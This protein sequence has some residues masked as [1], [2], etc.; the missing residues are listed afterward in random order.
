MANPLLLLLNDSA[1]RRRR[2]RLPVPVPSEMPSTDA[3]FVM[4]RRLRMPL[5]VLVVILTISV[6]GLTLIP[7]ADGTHLSPFDAL[8]FMTYTAATIGYTEIVD[9]TT[10]QRM[11]V[12]FCIYLSVV[13]WAYAIGTSLNLLQNATVREAFA[14]HRFAAGVKRIREEFVIVVGYGKAGRQVVLELDAHGRRVVVIDK[15]E[16]A[17]D[18]LGTESLFADVPGLAAN[19]AISGVLGLAGMGSANC[20]AVLALTDNDDDNL[21]IVMA[22]SLLRPDVPVIARCDDRLTADRMREFDAGAVIQPSDKFGEYLILAMERP[23]TYRLITSLMSDDNSKDPQRP[24]V[25]ADGRWVVVGDNEFARE[26]AADLQQES[27]P[28]DIVEP[29]TEHPD[30]EEAVGFIA[31]TENDTLNLALA[32]QARRDDDD[33]FIAVRQSTHS[34][35]A[36]LQ[37]LQIDAVFSPTDLV[38]NEALARVVTPVMWQFVEHALAQDDEWSHRL[39]QRIV[40]H[41]GETTPERRLIRLDRRDAP[42]ADRWMQHSPLVVGDLDRHPDDR[43]DSLRLTTLLIIRDDDAIYA[44][45]DDAALRRGDRVLIAGTRQSLDE[46]FQT[47]DYDSVVEY[48]ATGHQVPDGWLWRRLTR[49]RARSDVH[50]ERRRASG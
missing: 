38:A 34:H 21:A 22:G 31:G 1:T 32:E 15:D 13:G 16:D 10:P 17:I 41:C 24:P 7:N 25:P 8:Y 19:G 39:L 2:R 9:F 50:A 49:A 28:V 42:A 14:T 12:T 35:R 27:L 3:I 47:L 40:E 45:D 26:V 4:L 6:I 37:A 36:L 44:P 18:R 23:S 30:V 33:L 11:W 29:R 48:V 46:L 20:A 43:D 5:T